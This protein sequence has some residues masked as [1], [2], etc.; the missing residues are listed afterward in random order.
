MHNRDGFLIHGGRSN[1]ASDG[2]IIINDAENR[3]KI[4]E[5]IKAN[6]D[7]LEVVR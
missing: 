3:K 6:D 4:I 2:C 1:N 7:V 5:Q